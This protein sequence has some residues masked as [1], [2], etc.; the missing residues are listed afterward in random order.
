MNKWYLIEY[1]KNGKMKFDDEID[2]ESPSQALLWVETSC[3]NS[4]RKRFDEL[5]NWGRK[6]DGDE[7][8]YSIRI[9]VTD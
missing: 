5:K 3:N 4:D 1:L 2:A 8:D 6:N 9:T 7:N